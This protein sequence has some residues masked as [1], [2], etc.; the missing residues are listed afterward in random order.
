MAS[1]KLEIGSKIF[2]WTILS[3]RFVKGA[4]FVVSCRCD[5]GVEKDVNTTSLSGSDPRSKSCGCLAKEMATG[6]I[7]NPLH[8]G[9]RFERLVVVGVGFVENEC[10][11]YPVR[12]D[13]GVE[14][15]VRKY[16]LT[17]GVTRSCG[18]LSAELA[19][20]RKTNLSHGMS[21]T[22][23]YNAW[24][25]MKRR[26]YNESES[27]YESYGSRGIQV[28]ERWLE[29][30]E[31]FFEDM[32]L[33]PSPDMSVERLDVDGDYSPG[34]CVWA[35]KT[36]QAFNRRKFKNTSSQYIGVHFDKIKSKPWRVT[37]KKNGAIV[38]SGAFDTELEAALA[39]DEACMEHYGVRKNFPD[40]LT[41]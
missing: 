12:C 22:S 6:K 39:Y 15:D 25:S 8:I 3:D 19:G 32:R 31:N 30:F 29:S 21:G 11:I 27:S 7:K 40:M 4:G 41:E 2:R 38:F 10:A 24:N 35:D 23:E 18:C 20:Q 37:L 17:S 33:K 5:C 36:T 16:A 14:K 28:C 13:C 9:D 1:K 26:C 34:N